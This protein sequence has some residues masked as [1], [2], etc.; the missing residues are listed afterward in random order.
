MGTIL[1]V[2]C[3]LVAATLL[4]FG[5]TLRHDFVNFDDGQFVYE[6][7]RVT[8]GLTADGI[9]W[10]FTT[11]DMGLWVPL[12]R[13]S[14]MLEYQLYGLAPWGYHLGNLLLHAAT[15]ILLFLFL[16]RTTGDFWPAV[17]VAALF[18]VH[19]LRAESVAWVSERKG[20]LSGLFFLLTLAAYA[21]PFPSDG[22]C[23]CSCSLRWD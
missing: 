7:P 22:T 13:I 17:L 21:A 11:N 8:G 20:L 3:I 2:C 19:P 14:Y 4:V 6:N 1:G 15:T 5:Q 12:T 16:W 10:A 18:A 9:A 23:R